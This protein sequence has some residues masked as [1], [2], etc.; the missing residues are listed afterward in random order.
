VSTPQPVQRSADSIAENALA[1]RSDTRKDLLSQGYTQLHPAMGDASFYKGDEYLNA[2]GEPVKKP[3]QQ[4]VKQTDREAVQEQAQAMID[5]M[6]HQD[7]AL[8]VMDG[9]ISQVPLRLALLNGTSKENDAFMRNFDNG[10]MV[11]YLASF[12]LDVGVTMKRPAL[13][14]LVFDTT[15]PDFNASTVKIEKPEK[16]S[17]NK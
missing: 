15:A 4:D 6:G 8:L 1:L 5:S 17:K 12:G 13:E 16:A 3:E 10:Q 9:T 14:K 2:L 11:E 7:I